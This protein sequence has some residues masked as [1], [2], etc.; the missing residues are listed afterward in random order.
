[1]DHDSKMKLAVQLATAFIQNGDRRH[2][3]N[4]RD[5]NT[6][7]AQDRVTLLINQMY[8]CVTDA[9]IMA[10]QQPGACFSSRHAPPEGNA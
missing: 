4:Y 5:D 2:D 8:R 6:S 9:E 1:M 3:H 7:E 10:K